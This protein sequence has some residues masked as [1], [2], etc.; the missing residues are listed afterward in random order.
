MYELTRDLND[1]TRYCANVPIKAPGLTSN[2][3]RFSRY[4][5]T[6]VTKGV[7]DTHEMARR[8]R[9]RAHVASE[10]Q[11]DGEALLV[12]RPGFV[13]EPVLEAH[14][15]EAGE[16]VD[17]AHGCLLLFIVCHGRSGLLPVAGR[18]RPTLLLRRSAVAAWTR[19]QHAAATAPEEG[20]TAKES[21]RRSACVRRTRARSRP[22]SSRPCA[23]AC[24][25]CSR[26][27][28][29]ETASSMPLGRSF[30]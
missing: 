13:D 29:R 10:A 25:S 5:F 28:T 21:R 15:V 2:Q 3:R 11:H 18:G 9:A 4:L 22:L 6:T 20:G 24:S 1:E 19:V 30:A 17:Q 14:L 26:G 16:L 8:V 7:G 12:R 23:R 27:T